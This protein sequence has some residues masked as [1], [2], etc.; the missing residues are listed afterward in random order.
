MTGESRRLENSRWAIRRDCPS[1]FVLIFVAPPMAFFFFRLPPE[2]LD[3]VPNLLILDATDPYSM[4]S[5]DLSASCGNH[6]LTVLF[7]L[8]RATYNLA[9]SYSRQKSV[10]IFH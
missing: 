6:F 9:L 7:M 4:L 5:N 1:P 2:C 10:Y 8:L 3:L